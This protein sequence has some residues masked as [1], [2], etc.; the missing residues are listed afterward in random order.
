MGSTCECSLRCQ[1]HH[2]KNCKGNDE[3]IRFDDV[4]DEDFNSC[5]GNKKM[6]FHVVIDENFRSCMRIPPEVGSHFRKITS[7]TIKINAPN[8]CLYDIGVS[9]E[10]GEI[11]LR[12]GW[13]V[14]SA[15]HNLEEND[16]LVFKFFGNSTFK[17]QIYSSH[18]GSQKITSCV[19]PPS[20]I[21]EAVLPSTCDR[22]VSNGNEVPYLRH[23]QETAEFDYLTSGGSCLTKVQD[24][25]VLE[26]A[27][28]NRS[29]VPLYV[30]VMKT[31]NVDVESCYISIPSILLKNVTEEVFKA[32]VKLEAPDSNIYSVSAA[33]QSD[34]EIAL[35]SG[36]NDFVVAHRV[37]VG[38]LVI[39]RYK[40][41]SRLE[42]FILD[43][44]GCQKT[45][46]CFGKE[47]VSNAQEMCDDSVKIIDPPH[48]KVDIID[49]SSSSSDDDNNV[50]AYTEKLARL[51]KQHF[52]HCAKSR[53]IDSTSSQSI[54]LNH[55]IVLIYLV[56]YFAIYSILILYE[57]MAKISDHETHEDLQKYMVD[58]VSRSRSPLNSSYSEVPSTP[59]YI[60]S[61]S[62]TLSAAQGKMVLEKVQ[63]IG[64]EFPIFVSVMN[65]TSTSENGFPMSMVS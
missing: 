6:R 45:S 12:S 44:N 56:T 34:D 49:L 14:F 10:M 9:R 26:M 63:A 21:L 58:G 50:A 39:F 27:H 37:Q 1:D 54:K 28:T 33:Q 38:D 51:Q 3:K 59:L 23:N 11:V 35:Q 57:L 25:K 24:E 62:I 13:D 47:Y 19:S 46:S 65:R 41:N 42:V 32:T 61:G 16:S 15:A 52:D 48:S 43:R 60:I 18:G 55:G 29:Q 5:M 53:R 2:Y 22:H 7:E 64:S 20:E 31:T 40:G 4:A 8:G 36:W 30:A 17:V